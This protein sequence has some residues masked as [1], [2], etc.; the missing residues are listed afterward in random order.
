MGKCCESAVLFSHDVEMLVH[1]FCLHSTA[2]NAGDAGMLGLFI[3]KFFGAMLL[4]IGCV[5]FLACPAGK[6][7]PRDWNT[8]SLQLLTVEASTTLEVHQIVVSFT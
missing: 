5:T 8:T 2:N 7:K 4:R 6:N 3:S 1:N